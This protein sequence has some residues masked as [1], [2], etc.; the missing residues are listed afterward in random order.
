MHDGPGDDAAGGGGG[1]GCGGEEGCG[2]EDDGEDNEEDEEEDFLDDLL[3][4]VEQE[5][6]LKGLDNLETVWKA[7]EERLYQEQKGCEKR[8]SLLR[9]VLNIL[10]RRGSC[11]DTSC[12]NAASR[13][14]LKKS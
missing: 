11:L 9:F 14:T 8:W 13:P 1:D 2:G 10:I 4:H 5:L 7:R 12:S 6:L 3:R